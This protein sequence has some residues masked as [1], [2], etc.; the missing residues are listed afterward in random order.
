MIL[1]AV[2]RVKEYLDHWLTQVDE[3][4]LHSPFIY[5]FYREAINDRSA[6]KYWQKVQQL[7]Q[8]LLG[9]HDLIE[10]TDFGTGS[11]RPAY[12]RISDLARHS[13]QPKVSRLLFNISQHFHPQTILE[14]GTSLGLATLSMAGAAPQA[15]I[16]T[17]EGCPRISS[18]AKD[19]FTAAGAS[20]I[21]L[22]TGDIQQVLPE[23]LTRMTAIDLLFIDAN[24]RYRPVMD[25]FTQCLDNCH[26]RSVVVIDDIHWSPE[27]SRAWREISSMKQV[28]VS[29]DL[30]HAGIVFFN[31]EIPK[32]HYVLDL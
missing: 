24:H 6:N 30:F 16:V 25:Y 31:P 32:A 4:S 23:I 29:I 21:E 15:N 27:M 26:E 18:V 5:Q 22:I 20:A 7:R 10:V 2:S 9:K 8:H 14:L 1:D 19:N 17:V 12:R 28:K 3:H 13:N 11:S